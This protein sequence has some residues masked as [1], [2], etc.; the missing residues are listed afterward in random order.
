MPKAVRSVGFSPLA[1]IELLPGPALDRVMTNWRAVGI[2]FL[3]TVVVGLV[4]VVVPGIGQ[5][6]A[7]LVGGFVA[8]YTAGGG[9]LGGTWHG[10]LAGGL[11]GFLLALVIGLGSLALGP[12]GAI[13]GGG[14]VIVVL[15]LTV[16]LAL[17]SA[18]GGLVG[19]AFGG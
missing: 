4:G 17:D 10:L 18:V 16:V 7:G 6:F 12:I 5:L 8:G 1:A 19:G 13:V 14:I 2:G 15:L 3:V 9:L 11:A